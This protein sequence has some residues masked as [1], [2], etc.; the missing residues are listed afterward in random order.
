ME[1]TNPVR[2]KKIISDEL[3]KF[4]SGYIIQSKEWDFSI[5]QSISIFQ[6]ENNLNLFNVRLIINPMLGDDNTLTNEEKLDS[7]YMDSMTFQTVDEAKDYSLAIF[8]MFE[9]NE[10]NV[11]EFSGEAID[12]PI[13]YDRI[14]KEWKNSCN[15]N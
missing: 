13:D 8:K 2:M 1:T 14:L 5:Y 15:E 11:L 12:D 3:F 6:S 7:I 9:I 4:W 10:I